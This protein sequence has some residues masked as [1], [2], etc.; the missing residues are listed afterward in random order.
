MTLYISSKTPDGLEKIDPI[1][2]GQ[3]FN[4]DIHEV[5]RVDADGNEYGRLRHGFKNLPMNLSAVS[6]I[7]YGSHAKFIAK[8]F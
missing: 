5:F 3:H 1:Y 8:N 6:G 7:W 4:G 2:L